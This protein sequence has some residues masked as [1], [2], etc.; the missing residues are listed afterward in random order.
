MDFRDLDRK[1]SNNINKA[2]SIFQE[3]R[4]SVI[5][6]LE[7]ILLGENSFQAVITRNSSEN[8][9]ID[10]NF[11][12]RELLNGSEEV[13][14]NNT[15]N[16]SV[17]LLHNVLVCVKTGII[18]THSGHLYAPLRSDR[19]FMSGQFAGAISSLLRMK[20]KNSQAL[21][22]TERLVY[23]IPKHHYYYH[24]VVEELPRLLL[25]IKKFPSLI[26]IS[27]ES[28][29]NFVHQFLRDL[30][31]NI[32]HI[33]HPILVK[34]LIL[35]SSSNYRLTDTRREFLLEELD[36]HY[37]GMISKNQRV[38]P[39]L[40]IFISRSDSKNYNTFAEKLIENELGS[41]SYLKV[42]LSKIQFSDQIKLFKGTRYAVGI[43]G[44]GF[45]NGLFMERG[46]RIEEYF[47]QNHFPY[48]YRE[49]AELSG[50]K[51]S[52]RKLSESTT[53]V[54]LRNP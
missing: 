37:D 38:K 26:I 1:Q 52:A 2:K 17:D 40:N 5:K 23:L 27:T 18:R 29:P 6:G 36:E 53:K 34:G 49:I 12:I 16:F 42:E 43:H 35:V 33:E 44:G 47:T 39:N 7:R 22:Q 32:L 30:R 14:R 21:K 9:A 48:F 20:I 10:H 28:Q 45:T 51:Y 4:V 50:L 13:E 11:I 25:A 8:Q 54:N 31:L 19:E 3:P 46:G 24:F 15:L 41:R